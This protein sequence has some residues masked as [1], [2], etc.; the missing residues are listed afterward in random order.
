MVSNGSLDCSKHIVH[1]GIR[2][3]ELVAAD[4]L[5]HAACSWI[6]YSIHARIEV[7]VVI[8]IVE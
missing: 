6:L 5:A 1:G 8:V 2:I 3:E 4:V 7:E